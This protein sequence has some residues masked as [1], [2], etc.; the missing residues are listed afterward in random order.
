LR[1]PI[2]PTGGFVTSIDRESTGTDSSIVNAGPGRFF[3]DILAANTDYTIT[4]ENCAAPA[5]GAGPG[6][7][8]D[9]GPVNSSNG[10]I[11]DTTSGGPL[12]NTGGV[13]LL[14]F[15]AGALVLFGVGFSVLR[16]SIRRDP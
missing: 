5:T 15:A 16:T 9:Q 8:S 6:G 12:P 4:V 14:G 7:P 10:V 11:P 1:S 2:E 13:P 3:L